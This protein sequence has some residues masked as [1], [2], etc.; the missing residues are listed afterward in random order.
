M[1]RAVTRRP[2]LGQRRWLL[3]AVG[4]SLVLYGIVGF[5]T[6]DEIVTD[7]GTLLPF[8]EFGRQLLRA[9]SQSLMSGGFLLVPV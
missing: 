8:D 9:R 3:A 4:L 7:P 5:P 1:R 2:P 6:P